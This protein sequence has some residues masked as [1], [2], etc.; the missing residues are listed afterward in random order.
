L[1]GAIGIFSGSEGYEVAHNDICGNF[2]AEYGGGIS[3]YGLSPNGTIHHNRVYF[4]RAYDEGGGIMI[5]G[6]L[7]PNPAI[8]SAGV[9]A[10]DVYN[11]L[12]QANLAM[13]TA[14][15]CAS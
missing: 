7:P 15:G 3:H 2:S 13:T 6:E 5:A 9:G 11:N 12:V 8:L 4:N 14:V 1:A 10:V